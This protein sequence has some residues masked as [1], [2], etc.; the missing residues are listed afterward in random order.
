M[1]EMDSKALQSKDLVKE[2]S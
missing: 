2:A 1:S